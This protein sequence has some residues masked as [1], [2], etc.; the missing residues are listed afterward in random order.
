MC[1]LGDPGIVRLGRVSP[2]GLDPLKFTRDRLNSRGGSVG[3]GAALSLK[4]SN[5]NSL[6]VIIPTFVLLNRMFSNGF[7]YI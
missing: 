2:G 5:I 4:N 6:N 1:G 3:T 7:C